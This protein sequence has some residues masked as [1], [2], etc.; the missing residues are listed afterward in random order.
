MR[1]FLPV[2]SDGRGCERGSASGEGS[3]GDATF[4]GVVDSGVSKA[5]SESE[6]LWGERE[7][8]RDR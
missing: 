3:K 1:S 2:S 4:T 5:P 8:G 6:L 7:G